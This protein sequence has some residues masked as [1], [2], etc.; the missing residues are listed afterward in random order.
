[1][2]AIAAIAAVASTVEKAQ[3]EAITKRK[4]SRCRRIVRELKRCWQHCDPDERPAKK[5]KKAEAE[6][7][8]L[9]E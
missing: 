1:M 6:K 8:K 2:E 5:Q 9:V 3:C 7:E 4:R